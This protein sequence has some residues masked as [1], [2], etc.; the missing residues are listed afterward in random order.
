MIEV[1]SHDVV[2]YF[3]PKNANS[4][5]KQ[6]LFQAMHPGEEIPHM[7]FLHSMY[8]NHVQ[9]WANIKH[10]KK[11]S[12]RIV[13]VRDPVERWMSFY[14]DKVLDKKWLGDPP[15]DVVQ[16]AMKMQDYCDD[17]I[18]VAHHAKPQW[19]FLGRHP[20]LYT[21]I[22]KS[23]GLESLANVMEEIFGH[24]PQVTHE[25]PSKHSIKLLNARRCSLQKWVKT[26]W[27]K[28]DYDL[29]YC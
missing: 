29:G 11:Y 16:V 1:P 24:R 28:R 20:E 23:D 7:K 27:A 14:Q 26:R 18:R 21:H 17:N 12:R 6:M 13:V 8:N 10:G 9:S 22:I 4:S 2:F 5:C 25:N 3:L 15:P 19:K